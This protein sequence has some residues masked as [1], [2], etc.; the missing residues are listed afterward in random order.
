M[1]LIEPYSALRFLVSGVGDDE[2]D[3]DEDKSGFR[4]KV[5]TFVT[6]KNDEFMAISMPKL[7]FLGIRNFIAPGFSYAKYLAAYA[8]EEHKGFFPY[9]YI[10]SLEKLDET[11][12]PSREAFHSSLRNFDLSHWVGVRIM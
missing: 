7:K 5:K 3:E 8:I 11:S 1:N 2:E 4:Q 12:L 6:K 10:T 9:E